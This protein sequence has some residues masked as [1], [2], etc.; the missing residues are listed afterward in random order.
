MNK[1]KQILD[2]LTDIFKRWQVLLASLS[3]EQ[4]LSPLV[5]SSWTI[6]DTVAHLWSWQQ[7]SVARMEAALED[8]EPFY[9]HWWILR[10]PDPEDNVDA[11]NAL[12]HSLSKDK[13]WQQV[14]TEWKTQFTHYLE[15][16]GRIPEQDFIQ[17]GRYPWMGEYAIAD[18]SIGTL[19]H[20]QEHYDD[21]AAWLQQQAGT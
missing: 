21:L 7:G 3:E 18:S 15:L 4:L 5:P 19:E 1:K 6:K 8:R 13:P 20:H 16:T 14:Y 11:T 2:G 9:P 12:L 10:G 17:P